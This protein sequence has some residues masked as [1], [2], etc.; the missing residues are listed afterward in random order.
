MGCSGPSASG[1]AFVEPSMRPPLSTPGRWFCTI[2]LSRRCDRRVVHGRHPLAMEPVGIGWSP[3]TQVH[4]LALRLAQYSSVWCR[5][6]R[7]PAVP[8]P[9][10]IRVGSRPITSS[11]MRLLA[12][13]TPAWSTPLLQDR[14]GHRPSS[15]TGVLNRW[16]LL[17]L[18]RMLRR[19]PRLRTLQATLNRAPSGTTPASSRR[20]RS[21]SR[22]RAS[23]TIPMRRWRLFPPPKRS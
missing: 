5:A 19:A 14:S 12:P 21:I 15:T 1:M 3:P 18:L 7:V 4:S 10:S 9:P 6:G 17:K 11:R 23:A 20:H 2:K 22:R 16:R 13:V 8:R